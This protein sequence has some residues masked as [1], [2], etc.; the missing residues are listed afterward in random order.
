MSSETGRPITKLEAA[1]ARKLSTI[2]ESCS[3]GIDAVLADSLVTTALE[4]L[5]E[6]SAG[7]LDYETGDPANAIRSQVLRS[8]GS[9]AANLSEGIGKAYEDDKRKFYMTA[10]GSA[11]ETVIWLR[12]L[13]RKDLFSRYVALC[14]QIDA[15]ILAELDRPPSE[16]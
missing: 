3:A 7:L 10:R 16:E 4:L 13:G 2:R 6:L 1:R 12:A 5:D 8:S 9:V 15:A 11:Y 14:R